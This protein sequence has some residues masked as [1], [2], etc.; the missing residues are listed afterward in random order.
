[1]GGGKWGPAKTSRTGK[2]VE[3]G[4]FQTCC[5]AESSRTTAWSPSP[6]RHR[7]ERRRRD[8][9]TEREK[10]REAR[11]SGK[12]TTEYVF[13]LF[14]TAIVVVRFRAA[15]L[16]ASVVWLSLSRPSKTVGGA[17]A[18]GLGGLPS[19]P[20][21]RRKKEKRC[22]WRGNSVA[23]PP[24]RPAV[25]N[26]RATETRLLQPTEKIK[27]GKQNSTSSGTP[28]DNFDVVVVDACH[29]EQLGRN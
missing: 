8:G 19:G 18:H 25:K 26:G 9:K 5:E 13:S 28:A 21:P 7:R 20:Q 27:R 22:E 16:V 15:R 11:T 10:E 14:A 12:A 1:M 3:R 23:S 29:S 17:T 4:V 24:P 6:L 2:R